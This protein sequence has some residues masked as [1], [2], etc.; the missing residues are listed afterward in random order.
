[1][2]SNNKNTA[3]GSD[4]QRS[5][6]PLRGGPV[7]GR[8]QLLG[9]MG[10]I[11][12]A[13]VI[14]PA[15]LAACG[16]DDEPGGG[17]D[18][19]KDLWFE[20]WP[21]YI[22]E[23]TV[24]LFKEASGIDFRY[25]ENFNDNNE[26]FAKVQ[27]DLAASRSIGPDII[28]P[29]Y[30]LAARL[31]NLGWVQELPFDDIPNASN[32]LPELQNPD[33]DPDG[34][35]SLPW[36]SGMTGLAYNIKTTGRELKSMA[37]IFDPAFKGKV[38][39]LTEMRDTLGLVMLLTGE[40]PSAA[41]VD[42]ANAAFERIEEAKS[43]GHIRQ[44]TGNDYMDDLA[45]GNFAVC[46]GWSGDI[47]QLALDN[48]DL[49]FA[50]PEE[51]GMRW[52]DTMVIPNGAENVANAAVWMD[53]VYDPENAARITEF[54]GYN[55]PVAGV[56]EILA[57]GDDFQKALSESVLLFPDDATNARLHVFANLDEDTEAALDERFSS[58][59]GA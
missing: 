4:A 21:A 30:W 10:A 11:A 47:G 28:A 31:I 40:D 15:L 12:G 41:T 55:T 18:A 13:G 51:G 54:V 52:S 35:Y 24:D 43:S 16:D 2:S 1:M 7:L 8:R 14:G 57:G 26:Y 49:R 5:R 19:S 6:R 34:K 58:I 20:N 46:I 9:R 23:E 37:D 27:W 50:I 32:L 45:A 59:V 33:W 56:R 42:S 22:D 38:G 17:G 25:T 48:P 44:F 39:M 36:Q 3:G 53:Y 29:T